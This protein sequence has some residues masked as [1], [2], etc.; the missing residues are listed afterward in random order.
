MLCLRDIQSR[1]QHRANL[2]VL[3][4][5]LRSCRSE[6]HGTSNVKLPLA[7][8]LRPR[9]SFF[10]ISM[11]ALRNQRL[12]RHAALAGCDGERTAQRQY[13]LPHASQAEAKLVPGT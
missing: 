2:A 10:E 7:L 8:A 4:P 6:G 9:A 13:S 12:D 1:C 5:L 11:G 3:C